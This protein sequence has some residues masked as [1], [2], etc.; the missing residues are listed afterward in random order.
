MV[1]KITV[2][3]LQESAYKFLLRTEIFSQI[4]NYHRISDKVSRGEIFMQAFGSADFL[5]PN[6]ITLTA[7][8]SPVMWKLRHEYFET[9]HWEVSFT[10]TISFI[11]YSQNY[12]RSCD[13][14]R[15]HKSSPLFRHHSLKYIC[16]QGELPDT[17]YA[18]WLSMRR[19]F[20]IFPR[21]YNYSHMSLAHGGLGCYDPLSFPDLVL[22]IINQ[23]IYH[24]QLPVPITPSEHV[25][26]ILTCF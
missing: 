3:K 9:H 15:L 19:P 17:A 10:R 4:V 6:I 25:K 7:N 1:K 8:S 12:Y 16:H 5:W 21:G 18:D 14:G 20:R 24:S 11:P 2:P 22:T 13:L 26:I 23:W